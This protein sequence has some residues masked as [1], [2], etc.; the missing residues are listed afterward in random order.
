MQ[1]YLLKYYPSTTE[2]T[3]G[4]Y[5]VEESEWASLFTGIN[6]T[7]CYVD[8]Q[9][10]QKHQYDGDKIHYH[11]VYTGLNYTGDAFLDFV[12]EGGSKVCYIYE[13]DNGGN[14]MKGLDQRGQGERMIADLDMYFYSFADKYSS[15]EYD[16]E[17]KQYTAESI[18]VAYRETDMDIVFTDICIK[19]EDGKISEITYSVYGAEIKITNI[20]TTSVTLPTPTVT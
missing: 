10:D 14:W 5:C 2:E 6:L 3:D 13:A 11:T 18:T 12:L 1:N 7:F 20:G 16:A 9:T 15:F 4:G 8:S 17:D 19:L